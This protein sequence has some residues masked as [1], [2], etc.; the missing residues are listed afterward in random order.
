MDKNCIECGGDLI[1]PNVHR[2][3]TCLSID[4]Y[5]IYSCYR[6]RY[7]KE[8]GLIHP[9]PYL[10]SNRAKK[11]IIKEIN[12]KFNIDKVG[13]VVKSMKS[14]EEIMDSTNVLDFS[15]LVTDK[16]GL[17]YKKVEEIALDFLGVNGRKLHETLCSL[18]RLDPFNQ[19]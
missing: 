3:N 1:P 5:G 6:A 10:L 18:R 15:Q 2:D 8:C 9:V 14:D 4:I 12:H 13:I 16:F 17:S 7:C 11:A 19:P